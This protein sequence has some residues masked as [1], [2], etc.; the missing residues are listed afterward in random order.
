MTSPVFFCAHRPYTALRVR[1]MAHNPE[2]SATVGRGT[3][4]NRVGRFEATELEIDWTHLEHDD[5]FQ[6]EIARPATHC[7]ED[8]SRTVI[9]END[10]AD[11]PYRYSLNPYRGCQ[12]GCS[13]CYA[14]PSHEFLGLSAGLDFETKIFVKRTAPDLFRRWLCRTGYQPDSVMMSGITDCYQPVERA[15][16]ITR[17]CL[18]VAAGARQPMALITKNALIRRDLDII[19]PMARDNLARAAIS[20]TSLDQSLTRALEPATSAPA[21]RLDAVR[22]LTEQGVPVH[23]MVSPVIPGLNDA[24]IPAILE[25]ARDAGAISAS[26]ILLRLPFSVREIFA[27]WLHQRRPLEAGKVLSQIRETRDGQLNDVEF[28]RRMRGTGP[29]ADQIAALFRV[30]ASRLGLDRRLPPL[31]TDLFRPPDGQGRL[32]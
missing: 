30:S 29:L 8:T 22:Q 9:S 4:Q 5:E 25:A 17:Q 7:F 23:V 1:G 13:Y 12:H 28:G 24:E 15:L 26:Y 6:Q 19:A 3:G 14:R 2:S 20:I 18:E 21:A 31:A 32:F 27:D 16:R 11:I 10:S